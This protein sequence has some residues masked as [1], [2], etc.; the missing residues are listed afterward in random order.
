MTHA[1]GAEEVDGLAGEGVDNGLDLAAG[2]AVMLEDAHAHTDAVLA[3]GRPVELLHTSITDQG[4]VQGGEIVSCAHHGHT[5]DLLLQ[6]QQ[7]QLST[8]GCHVYPGSTWLRQTMIDGLLLQCILLM[9]DFYWTA[10]IRNLTA[11]A[12]KW[13][14]QTIGALHEQ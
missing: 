3:G 12:V 6:A 10:T 5:G 2:D 4:R 7:S 14:L 11:N 8:D 9:A 13:Q 1:E